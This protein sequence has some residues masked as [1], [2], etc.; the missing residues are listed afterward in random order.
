[1]FGIVFVVFAFF[2]ELS[3][4]NRRRHAQRKP[5]I[6]QDAAEK[7][8]KNAEENDILRHFEDFLFRPKS[9]DAHL[10]L[11]FSALRGDVKNVQDVIFLG[12]F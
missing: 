4:Q 1:M 7:N 5:E 8:A 6:A 2:A 11:R 9:K 10:I 12:V 3:P